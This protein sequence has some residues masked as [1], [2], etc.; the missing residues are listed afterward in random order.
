MLIAYSHTHRA[1]KL[2][3]TDSIK[4]GLIQDIEVDENARIFQ[5]C[6]DLTISENEI[7]LNGN[8]DMKNPISYKWV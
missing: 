6:V 8:L 4:V 7:F 5:A 2:V 1:Y 3:Y